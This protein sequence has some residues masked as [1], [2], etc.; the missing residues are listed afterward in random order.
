MDDELLS[1]HEVVKVS[2]V[3]SRTLR[4]Y[5][6]IGL[7][8]PASVGHGG[9]RLYSQANLLRLQQILLLRELDLGL[10]QIQQVLD[11]QRDELTALREH[12]VRIRDA[13]AR[14]EELQRTVESTI[15]ALEEGRNMS[16]AE[17][18]AGFDP[19]RQAAYESELLERFGAGVLEHIDASWARIAEMS[20]DDAAAISQGYADVE[21]ALTQLLRGGASPGDEIVQELIALHYAIVCKF[22]TPDGQAYAGLAE[23]YVTHPDFK[24]RYDAHDESLAEFLRDAMVVYATR[25]LAVAES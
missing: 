12:R 11:G 3:T 24:A 25:N 9:I 6:A 14:L 13:A 20:T 10:P 4:H 18:F 17:I 8:K 22:W 5:D 16:A 2:G 19:S 1:I 15:A 23:L 7:L 21:V